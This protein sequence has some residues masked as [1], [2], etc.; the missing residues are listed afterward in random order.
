MKKPLSCPT[1]WLW[2]VVATEA[3]GKRRAVVDV[4]LVVF[5]SI[6]LRVLHADTCT[7]LLDRSGMSFGVRSGYG[8]SAQGKGFIEQK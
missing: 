8:R 4:T 6:V 7:S 1:N 3:A 2:Y 5:G